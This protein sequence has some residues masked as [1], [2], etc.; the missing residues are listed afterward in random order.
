MS[1]EVHVLMVDDDEGDRKI[2]RRCLLKSGLKHTVTEVCCV[3]E[4]V[5]LCHAMTFDC[6]IMDYHMP[7]A[8]GLA[9]L[10]RI[11]KVDAHLPVVLVTGQGCELLASRAFLRGASDY[12]PKSAM[13]PAF[14]RCVI[15]NAI[16]KG[17]MEQELNDHKQDLRDFAS[18]L[19][20]DLSGPIVNLRALSQQLIEAVKNQDLE[21]A[22]ELQ[23]CVE[24]SADW[25]VELLET[26]S[27]FNQLKYSEVTFTEVNLDHPLTS[28]LERLRPLLQDRKAIVDWE[29][30]PDLKI[31]TA[32]I[33]QLFQHL[34]ENTL[35]YGDCDQ[36]QIRIWAERDDSHW[37]VFVQDNGVGIPEES[38]EF[39]F[40]PMKRLHGKNVPGSGLGLSICRRIVTRH[41]GKIW[42]ESS[43]GPGACFAIRLPDIKLTES[44]SV[45]R[46]TMPTLLPFQATPVAELQH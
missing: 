42:C 18:I 45:T 41:G 26:L 22:E 43:Q 37:N 27:R 19:S 11:K 23:G 6:L 4:A 1:H 31:N 9:G 8:D 3:D 16:Q 33:S 46:D 7:G 10:D 40:Q 28:A 29:R 34:I 2:L 15:E 32:L 17:R 25:A 24:R 38:H 14:L 44:D 21:G 39:I 30:L 13:D 5:Q 35:K 12:V 36:P 20:H